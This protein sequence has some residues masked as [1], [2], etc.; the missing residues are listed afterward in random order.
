MLSL[1]FKAILFQEV[2]FWFSTYSMNVIESSQL[3]F[4][5]VKDNWINYNRPNS[6]KACLEGLLK[7][8]YGGAR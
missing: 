7:T 8:S 3:C 1:P 4:H 5:R 6:N 2:V